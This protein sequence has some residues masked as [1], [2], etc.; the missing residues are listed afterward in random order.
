MTSETTNEETTKTRRRTAKAKVDPAAA[1]EWQA[2]QTEADV[3]AAEAETTAKQEAMPPRR[4]EG[5]LPCK[6]TDD[7]RL[8]RLD[9]L[10]TA[11]GLADTLEADRKLANDGAKARIKLQ[12]ERV[13]ELRETLRT[14]TEERN[15]EQCER[16]DLR[17]CTAQTIRQDTGEIV[18][19]RALRQSE[20]QPDLPMTNGENGHGSQ[21]N[22]G[23]A[24]PTDINDAASLL[25]D[26]RR[27]EEPTPSNISLDNDG[28]DDAL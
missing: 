28:E 10:E 17:R 5:L 1:A 6:L 21:M 11:M 8:E 14:K 13:R 24:D 2:A 16:F 22:L 12:M 15:V 19:E 3:A 23:D 27:G 25:E 26:A 7:E 18:S 9:E 4:F 20:L